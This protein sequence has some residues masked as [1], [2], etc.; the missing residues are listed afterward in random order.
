MFALEIIY[1]TLF[2][3]LLT[4]F[5]HLVLQKQYPLEANKWPLNLLINFS[6]MAW[7]SESNFNNELTGKNF[8]GIQIKKETNKQQESVFDYQSFMQTQP[9]RVFCKERCS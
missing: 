1:C 7:M 8:S 2:F 5:L 4:H 3:Y 9:G 6:P